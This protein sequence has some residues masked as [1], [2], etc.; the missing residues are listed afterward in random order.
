[1]QVQ[2]IEVPGS[3]VV[4][5]STTLAAGETTGTAAVNPS[6]TANTVPNLGVI[7]S[8][9]ACESSQTTANDHPEAYVTAEIA[10]G[11]SRIDFARD[12]GTNQSVDVTW[13]AV[14]WP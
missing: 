8:S 11:G 6:A 1:M 3:T 13:E 7:G 12:V 9:G 4:R 2:V 10:G 14:S 5:G